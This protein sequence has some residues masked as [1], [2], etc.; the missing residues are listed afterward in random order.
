MKSEPNTRTAN[1]TAYDQRRAAG[2]RA[3]H[4]ARYCDLNCPHCRVEA[5]AYNA[6]HHTRKPR[7][8]RES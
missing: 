5:D 7:A 3:L 1:L 4:E 6:A 2:L 8:V